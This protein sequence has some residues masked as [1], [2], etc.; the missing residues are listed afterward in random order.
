MDKIDVELLSAMEQN[1]RVSLKNLAQDLNVK[2]S[3]IYHRLHKLEENGYLDHYSIVINPEK[4][5]LIYHFIL[6]IELKRNLIGKMDALFLESFMKYLTEQFRQIEFSAMDGDEKI[7]LIVSF[8]KKDHFQKFLK[9]LGENPYIE[10]LKTVKLSK[11][12]NG[13]KLFKFSFDVDDFA[14]D[15]PSKKKSK[16]NELN[17]NEQKEIIF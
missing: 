16:D 4:I 13:K 10:S 3:T 14:E 17:K 9:E 7:W 2:T 15:K 11:I 8:R 12:M 1:S 6:T 5:G